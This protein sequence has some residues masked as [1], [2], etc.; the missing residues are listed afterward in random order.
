MKMD[1]ERCAIGPV[2][3]AWKDEIERAID[4]V[5]RTNLGRWIRRE[6]HRAGAR[7]HWS[8]GRKAEW[9]GWWSRRCDGI[10]GQSTSTTTLENIEALPESGHVDA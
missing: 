3:A 6:W 2:T 4:N 7:D 5:K 10:A 8:E 9:V 1:A